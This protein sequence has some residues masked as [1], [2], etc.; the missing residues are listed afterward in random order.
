MDNWRNAEKLLVVYPSDDTIVRHFMEQYL[1]QF[2][3]QADVQRHL[4]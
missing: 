1:V 3:T 2:G 4:N